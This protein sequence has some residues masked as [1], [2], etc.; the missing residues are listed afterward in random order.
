MEYSVVRIWK[1]TNREITRNNAKKKRGKNF[2]RFVK[3]SGFVQNLKPNIVSLQK[4]FEA[5]F[6]DGFDVGVARLDDAFLNER[7]QSVVE[8]DHS[9][10]F[11]GLHCRRD[12]E[13]FALADKIR[14]GGR[15]D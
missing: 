1:K 4:R 6:V 13:G 9:E 11:S 8:H 12:L 2:P 7:E 3:K 5:R 15:D 10:L 14:D